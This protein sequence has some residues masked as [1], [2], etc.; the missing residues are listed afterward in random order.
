MATDAISVQPS[1]LPPTSYD[2][3]PYSSH[4]YSQTHPNRLAVMG[5]LFGLKTAPIDR[6]RVLEL[7]CASGGNLTPVAASFPNSQF[8]GLD[9]SSRQIA[10]GQQIIGALGLKNIEL[11]HRSIMDVDLSMG[12]FDYIVCHGVYSWVPKEVRDKILVICKEQLEPQG[13]AYI[14][15][16]TYPGWH[17]RGTVR[18]MMLYHV[19]KWQTPQEKVG[20][21]RA[22]LDFLVK[23]VPEDKGAYGSLLRREMDIMREQ[24]D[25][26]VLH[27]HLESVNEPM[28]FHEFAAQ[29]A[30]HDL[31]FL[32]EADL[33]AMSLQGLAA[34]I[35]NIVRQLASNLVELEQYLDFIRNRTF[36]RTLLCHTGI[37]L[38]WQTMHNRIR[39]LHIA[40]PA[41]PQGTIDVL[42]KDESKF[43]TAGGTLSTGSPIIKAALI[44]LGERWPETLPFEQ[45]MDEAIRR[46][47]PDAAGQAAQ[48]ERLAEVLAK[49]LVHCFA[50]RA[51]Q[52]YVSA[53]SITSRVSERPRSF[54]VARLQSESTARV[55]S[56]LH[57]LVMLNEVDR[58]LVRL[59]NGE[60]TRDQIRGQLEGLV[61]EGKLIPAA[62]IKDDPAKLQKALE[63][64]TRDGLQ[65]LA[66]L[67]LLE[68]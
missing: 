67:A 49:N 47:I 61:R 57:E 7:G 2:E 35:R 28:Y 37:A 32:A 5:T 43:Q 8:V 27:E 54:S 14:S 38:D 44:V 18:D 22:L 36:R 66:R 60:R 4:P 50:Q 9:L 59:A 68:A 42:A 24:A 6:C 11:Q 19:R 58:Q 52:F 53:L 29:A 21:A 63:D 64:S 65:R 34:D 17:M 26:Y 56:L 46:L 1:T 45:L 40:S 13:V 48:R 12:K 20:H 33:G 23:S 31:Q 41:V 30:S 3:V 39:T 51:V 16:N 25:H 15:Y 10:D 62:G 55:T